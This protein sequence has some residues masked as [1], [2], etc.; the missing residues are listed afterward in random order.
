MPARSSDYRAQPA[1]VSSTAATFHWAVRRVLEA[2]GGD[3]P[4]VLVLDDVQWAD[5]PTL[6]LLRHLVAWDQ[7]LAVVV[8]ATFRESE[9]GAGHPLADLLAWLHREPGVT[10]ISLRGLGDVELLAL[11][12]AGAGHAV[13]DNGLAL[14]DAL[15]RE[16]DGNPF[17]VGE[18]LRHLVETGLVYQ[19]AEGRWTVSGDLRDRGL[20]VSV[21]EVIG[22]RVARLGDE[23]V[24][25][26]SV[27]AVIGRD[28]DL[29]VLSSASDT[30]E[31]G[32]AR[33]AWTPPS[34]PRW[35]S[36]CPVSATA[37]LTPWSSTPCTTR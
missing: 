22:R 13:D 3:H 26:L 4:V 5:A 14:R 27:A 9:V 12:E 29:D 6:Q 10:R 34:T 31:D 11:M 16:T 1:G 23:A 35:W 21:R 33:R 25:V 17:F 36:T 7:P 30:A 28:F 19:D 8:V 2:A 32:V 18:L 20:P 24:R 37:S 15:A